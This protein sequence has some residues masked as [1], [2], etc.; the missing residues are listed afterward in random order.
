MRR[1]SWTMLLHCVPHRLLA[2]S[3]DPFKAS[4]LVLCI[5][6]HRRCGT[7]PL[8]CVPYRSPL[9][10]AERGTGR[11][12]RTNV[13]LPP[14]T[15]HQIAKQQQPQVDQEQPQVRLRHCVVAGRK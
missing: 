10:I 3:S 14:R 11:L 13:L 5:S 15:G 12:V 1:R 7:M 9:V 8:H 2:D 6:V 4:V